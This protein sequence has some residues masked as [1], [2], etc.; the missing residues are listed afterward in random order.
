MTSSLLIICRKATVRLRE[1]IIP[2]FTQYLENSVFFIENLFKKKG[3]VRI[4]DSLHRWG[5][6]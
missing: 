4:I 2:A 5:I 3:A 1:E 6:K